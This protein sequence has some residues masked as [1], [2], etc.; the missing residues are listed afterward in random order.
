MPYYLKHGLVPD[1]PFKTIDEKGVGQ[2]VQLATDAARKANPAIHIGVCG[3]HG[4]VPARAAARAAA[5][6]HDGVSSRLMSRVDCVRSL[7]PN[8]KKSLRVACAKRAGRVA[9]ARRERAADDARSRRPV[10]RP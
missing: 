8:E 9:V 3:E 5:A 7:V 6:T 4:C 1:D 2:L 10:L